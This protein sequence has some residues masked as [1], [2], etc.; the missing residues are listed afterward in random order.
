MHNLMG[1]AA[2]DEVAKYLTSHGYKILERNWKNRWGEIDIIAE[3][4]GCVHFVE[5]K[6]RASDEQGSG[7]EYITASKLRQMGFAAEM[8]MSDHE[9][10]DEF[11]LSAAE[12]SGPDFR[13]EFLEEI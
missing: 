11:V 3:K 12:V 5:V 2:E 7:L 8:W 1:E 6:Y 10:Y 9:K 13:V 4:D